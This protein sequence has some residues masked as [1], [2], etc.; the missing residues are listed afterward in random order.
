MKKF[1]TSHKHIMNKLWKSHEIVVLKWTSPEKVKN[2]FC[3]KLLVL[4]SPEQ[5][6]KK[7]RKIVNKLWKS[8]EQVVNKLWTNREQ[9]MTKL[10]TSCEPI[11]VKSCKSSGQMNKSC[12]SPQQVIEIL[13][14]KLWTNC[15]KIMRK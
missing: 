1:W 3:K 12:T 13:W 15:D 14:K 4:T 9:V 7:L 8:H 10:Y 2:K 11:L 5:V 6:V